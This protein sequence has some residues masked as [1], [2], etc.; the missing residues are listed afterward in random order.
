[1]L[2]D[3]QVA[4]FQTF[5]FLVLQQAF[6]R[7]EMAVIDAEFEDVMAADRAGRPF[8]VDQRHWVLG[9]A[10]LRPTMRSLIEDDRIYEPMEQL[11]GPELM[12][13]GSGGNYYVGDTGW[14]PDTA[15][16]AGSPRSI[17][18]A[19]YLDPVA[20]ATGCL[21]LIP[22]S[23]RLPLHEGLTVLRMQRTMQ[24]MAEGRQGADALERLREEGVDVGR[25]GFGVRPEGVPA[26]AAESQPG[27]VVMFDQ[28]TYHASF[29][30]ESGRRMLTLNY[31]T[32]PKT[33]EALAF[34][35]QSYAS[36]ATNIRN[37]GYSD[38]DNSHDDAVL[39]SD[40]PRL[41]RLVAPLLELGFR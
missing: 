25:P 24:A 9:C 6:S 13:W 18:V 40:R 34:L 32:V 2:T 3:A 11:L 15:L 30:G 12:W 8:R 35:R 16:S 41:Q 26:Y 7:A 38:R 5:G 37:L 17:K 28:S 23:H 10:E 14:H 33:E 31:T 29:G 39:R 4:F 1:M 21:R 36:N 27:D 20:R 22:G 19:F